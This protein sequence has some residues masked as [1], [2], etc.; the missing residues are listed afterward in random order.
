MK[1]KAKKLTQRKIFIASFSFL[2]LLLMHGCG[3]C[4]GGSGKVDVNVGSGKSTAGSAI[5][6]L[7]SL[8]NA[9]SSAEK[10][11]ISV[12]FNGV[13]TQPLAEGT[14]SSTFEKTK[15]FEVTNSNVNPVPTIERKNLRPGTWTVT[16]STGTWSTT[17]NK[18]INADAATSFTFNY[19]SN[20][21]N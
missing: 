2:F 3:G 8:T 10:E 20:G 17:C 19:N 12:S 5:I 4:G 18:L 6:T 21:C 9:A 15:T 16:V 13:C 7:N 1:H 14:G 11:Y